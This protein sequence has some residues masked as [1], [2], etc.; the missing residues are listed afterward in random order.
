MVK[1]PTPT[2]TAQNL[3][4]P[5]NLWTMVGAY[6][7][8]AGDFNRFIRS[9][10]TFFVAGTQPMA[11]KMNETIAPASHSICRALYQRLC[12]I[13]ISLPHPFVTEQ[14]ITEYVAALAKVQLSQ[15]QEIMQLCIKH[16]ALVKKHYDAKRFVSLTTLARL[17]AIS[18]ILDNINSEIITSVASFGQGDTLNI[19]NTGITRIPCSL[20]SN[21]Q[22]QAYF[23]GLTEL[24]CTDNFIRTLRLSDLPALQIFDIENNRLHYL[25]IGNLPELADVR[26]VENNLTGTFDLSGFPLLESVAVGSNALTQINVT[27]LKHLVSLD[28]S[29]NQLREL[30]VDSPVICDLNCMYNELHALNVTHVTHLTSHLDDHDPTIQGLSVYDNPEN[31]QFSPKLLAKFG[32]ELTRQLNFPDVIAVDNDLNSEPEA[33]HDNKESSTA[34][35]DAEMTQSQSDNDSDDDID[36]EPV[37]KRRTLPR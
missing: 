14:P 13:D 17:E 1:A 2:I 9:C 19:S 8:K 37:H 35:P 34:A 16:A 6:L 18:Q 25:D 26:I 33:N 5:L 27:G 11:T 12:A 20:F 10:K 36:T 22:Y 29:Y 30:T 23:H 4:V 3:G 31:I 15:E 24:H 32:A 7:T 21:P 28:C